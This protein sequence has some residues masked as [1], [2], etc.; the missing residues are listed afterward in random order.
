MILQFYFLKSERGEDQ[1]ILIVVVSRLQAMTIS[2]STDEH[3]CFSDVN[4]SCDP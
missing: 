4:V 1:G 2:Q 3:D